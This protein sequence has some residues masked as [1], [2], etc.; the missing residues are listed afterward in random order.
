MNTK[1]EVYVSNVII[2]YADLKKAFKELF[3]EQSVLET[4]GNVLNQLGIEV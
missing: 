2:L 3:A 1:E 4:L